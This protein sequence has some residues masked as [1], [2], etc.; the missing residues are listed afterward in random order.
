MPGSVN[1]GTV[2]ILTQ[3]SGRSG[4][5]YQGYASGLYRQ[6]FLTLGDTALAVR[7]VSD[8]IA[9]SAC[10]PRRGPPLPKQQRNGRKMMQK[11]GYA[12]A[13]TMAAAGAALGVMAARS[14]PDMRWY[15]AMKKM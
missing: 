2:L 10:W 15:V 11:L 9:E 3:G 5:I 13:I 8:V 4:D 6:A 14:L 7:V 12:T 1:N